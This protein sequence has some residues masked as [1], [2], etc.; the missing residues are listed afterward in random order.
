MQRQFIIQTD[1]ISPLEL[2]L[3]E[4][5]HLSAWEETGK[6]KK[7]KKTNAEDSEGWGD[8]NVANG[9]GYGGFHDPREK[10]SRQRGPPRMQRGGRGG[11]GS[12]TNR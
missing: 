3:E 10:G 7:S 4:G 12:Q 11:S 9:G 5:D 2:L 6:K 1:L 8:C